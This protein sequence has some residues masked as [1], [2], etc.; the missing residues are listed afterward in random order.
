MEKLE[1]KIPLNAS[2]MQDACRTSR[3]IDEGSLLEATEQ[4]GEA[5]EE[6]V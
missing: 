4:L 1:E 2:R 6:D 3:P 5:Q